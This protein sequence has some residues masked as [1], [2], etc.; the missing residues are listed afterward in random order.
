MAV[1][2]DQPMRARQ[3]LDLVPVAPISK[4]R[5]DVEG[6]EDPFVRTCLDAHAVFPKN[7][8]RAKIVMEDCVLRPILVAV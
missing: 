6:R 5:M 3:Q 8:A 7:A 4:S 1:V 2:V